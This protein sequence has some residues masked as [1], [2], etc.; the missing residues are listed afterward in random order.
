MENIRQGPDFVEKWVMKVQLRFY[1]RGG[2]YL[3]ISGNSFLR[4]T[5]AQR[6]AEFSW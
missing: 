5:D 6:P 1:D 2:Q 4:P 3:I